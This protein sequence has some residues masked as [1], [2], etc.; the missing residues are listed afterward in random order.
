[1]SETKCPHCGAPIFAPTT[2]CPQCGGPRS[3]EEADKCP[4][5]GTARTADAAECP[6]CGYHFNSR[7]A[8]DS[9]R[10]A[11][12]PEPAD[13]TPRRK[14]PV[15]AAVVAAVAVIVGVV[16]FFTVFKSNNHDDALAGAG[17]EA[18]DSLTD[19]DAEEAPTE[20]AIFGTVSKQRKYGESS[21]E[22]E[23]P[24]SGNPVLVQNVREWI[25][26]ALGG[27]YQG[28]L[29][30]A[31]A[32]FNHYAKDLNKVDEGYGEYVQN[33][34]HLVYENERI[35]TFL[36]ES[37][38]YGGGAHG[39]SASTGTTFRKSDGKIFTNDLI[40]EYHKLKP[41]MARGLRDYFSVS[42]DEELLER[43]QLESR[44]CGNID[45]IPAPNSHPW[46]TAEG[47]V[48]LYVPYEI[49]CY[50]D[51]SPT[52]VLPVSEVEPYVMATAKSF[53]R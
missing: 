39:I 27:T 29:D 3:P 41:A 23:Y 33:K 8:A 52:F 28:L 36:H 44:L 51:G 21:L 4:V 6:V 38:Y 24:V 7:S 14:G 40:R 20:V 16:L 18:T 42:T 35:I 15:I 19:D 13:P 50:A 53:F 26:E 10:P 30:D 43:V 47:I 31:N 1:M 11:L 12:Q 17:D 32:F 37:S 46:I 5:C 2:F 25:N 22:I 49:A 45:D 9:D 34:I 48:F